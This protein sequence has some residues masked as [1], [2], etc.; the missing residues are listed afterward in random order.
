MVGGRVGLTSSHRPWGPTLYLF[1]HAY[2]NIK[3]SDGKDRAM[4][5]GCLVA[6]AVVPI[7]CFLDVPAHRAPLLWASALLYALSLNPP[8]AIFGK[9]IRIAPSLLLGLVL[10]LVGLRLLGTEWWNLKQ[11]YTTSGRESLRLGAES[12]A[13]LLDLQESDRFKAFEKRIALASFTEKAV[14]ISPL[15]HKLYSLGA[16]LF[17]LLVIKKIWLSDIIGSRGGWCLFPS[18]FHCNKRLSYP[19]IMNGHTKDI[20]SELITSERTTK[21]NLKDQE[22]ILSM[23]V[24]SAAKT[25]RLLRQWEDEFHAYQTDH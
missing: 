15:N 4:R 22:K 12:Y 8:E 1:F 6:A 7:H 21:R 13:N 14:K 3:S 25:P 2:R 23:V 19:L 17:F 16:W 24:D 5:L 20:W 18:R 10:L 9:R 11:P